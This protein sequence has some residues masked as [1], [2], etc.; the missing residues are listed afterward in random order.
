MMKPSAEEMDERRKKLKAPKD[1]S[2]GQKEEEEEGVMPFWMARE[3]KEEGK[4]AANLDTYMVEMASPSSLTIRTPGF[5]AAN[6][7][8]QVKMRL[9]VLSN[10]DKIKAGARLVISKKRKAEALQ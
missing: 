2:Q 7:L 3:Q 4:E 8:P 5:A 10:P 6:K 9:P 1:E